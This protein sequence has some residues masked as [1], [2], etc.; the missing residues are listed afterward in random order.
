MSLL[1]LED[2][3]RQANEVIKARDMNTMNNL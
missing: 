1:M 3:I 2:H